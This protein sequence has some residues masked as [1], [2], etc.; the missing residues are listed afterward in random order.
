[1]RRDDRAG[2]GRCG[3]RQPAALHPS[4]RL[5]RS[6][7][8]AQG[9][10]ATSCAAEETTGGCTERPPAPAEH[11]RALSGRYVTA[12]AA[13]RADPGEASRAEGKGDAPR[14]AHPPSH[15]LLAPGDA[16]RAG[17]S[18]SG[19]RW[20]RRPDDDAALHAPEPGGARQRH[21]AL[22]TTGR[23]AV[24]HAR[25]RKFWRHFGDG[26]AAVKTINKTGQETGGEAGIRTL[27]RTLKAL[28]RFSKPPPSAS[29][30]PHRRR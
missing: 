13:D 25:R 17:E 6:G 12:H 7:D 27:G 8:D 19:A 30:P 10:A 29:R 21:S 9:W 2:V 15:V 5:E 22:G 18:D 24:G 11:P 3:S 16:R 26:P 1:M 4:V 28:Q 23:T 14:G 20:T